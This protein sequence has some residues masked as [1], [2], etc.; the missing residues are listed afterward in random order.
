MKILLLAAHPDDIEFSMG[1]TV[2]KLIK[3]GHEINVEIFCDC[4]ITKECLKSME[5]FNLKPF[6]Y[7]YKVRTLP[8]FRQEIL[9][10]LIANRNEFNYDII[11]LPCSFDIHQDH[12]VIHNEGVRAF[13]HST[14]FGYS[15]PWNNISEDLRHFEIV[16]KEDVDT[17]LKAIECYKSQESRYYSNVDF[18]L[19][20]VKYNGKK[21]NR[22]FAECFEIIRQI[23]E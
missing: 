20:Q 18:I 6:N 8:V 2:S 9:D 7:L 15:F 12:Q 1:A 14:I 4:D 21:I 5:V 19:S 10:A 17:K 3:Q 22:Q 13:K 23:K 16:T 11:Y